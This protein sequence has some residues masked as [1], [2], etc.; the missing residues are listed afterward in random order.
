MSGTSGG[1]ARGRLTQERKSWRKDHPVGF[2]ARPTSSLTG[3][4]DIFRW[5]TGI[6][7]KEDTDWEGGVYKVVLKFTDEY[8]AKPPLCVFQP[9]IFHPNVFSNGQICLSIL[10]DGWRPGITVKQ[11]LLGIQDLLDTPN[12][13]DPANGP[14]NQCFIRSPSMYKKRVQKEALKF[15]PKH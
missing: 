6:P 8:P 12:K 10:G 7:G 13:G 15:T 14:A 2:F 4:S 1:I 3:S 9:P 5:E 11:I